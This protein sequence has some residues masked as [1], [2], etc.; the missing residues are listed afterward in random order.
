MHAGRDFIEA[1]FTRSISLEEIS[2]A[3]CLS[4]YHFLRLFRSTFGTTPGR[5]ITERRIEEARRLLGTT[6]LPIVRIAEAIGFE[7]AG[8][9][10]HLF[11]QRTG[12]TPGSLRLARSKKIGL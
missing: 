10:A 9:F 4:S 8:S 3:A 1:N 5:Y 11:R 6:D 12:R 2:R 7:S